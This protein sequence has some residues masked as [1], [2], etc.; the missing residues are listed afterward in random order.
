MHDEQ[1]FI[2]PASRFL[3][4]T[5]DIFC[6][7]LGLLVLGWVILLF[8]VI[9]S[10]DTRQNGFF[11]QE[12]I[13]MGG[14]VFKIIKLRTMRVNKNITTTVT[15]KNDSRITTIGSIVRKLKI[16]EFPQFINVL[17]GSMSFVGPRPD[18]KG[19]ADKLT[20]LDVAVLHIR[21]GITGVSSLAFRD[22]EELLSNQEDPDAYNR[23][24]I[25]PEKTRL[26]VLYIKHYSFFRDIGYILETL[27][28]FTFVKNDGR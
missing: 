26:N 23:V 21:P 22:E 10:I 17:L 12:R 1:I 18:V 5:F 25:Y 4:R 13:G 20:G 6:A 7:I 27:T 3:K 14:R 24:V 9:M 11:I 16:D 8:W 15:T 19:F 2:P 28:G